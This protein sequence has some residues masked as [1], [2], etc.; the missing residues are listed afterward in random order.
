[1]EEI[2]KHEKSVIRKGCNIQKVQHEESA[3]RKKCSMKGMQHEENMKS[4]N[5]SET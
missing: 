1:M 5:N 2:A 4:E 3:T